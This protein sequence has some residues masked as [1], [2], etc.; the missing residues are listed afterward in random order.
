MDVSDLQALTRNLRD[1][2]V[3]SDA[4]GNYHLPI[5]PSMMPLVNATKQVDAYGNE[6]IP[7]KNGGR[8]KLVPL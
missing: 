7:L 3:K 5:H 4:D 8:I 1:N 2:A 6:F